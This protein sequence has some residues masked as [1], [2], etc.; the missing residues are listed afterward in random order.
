MRPPSP[1]AT[2]AG[3]TE[4]RGKGTGDFTAYALF[5]SW[6]PTSSTDLE[7]WWRV[8]GDH[9]LKLTLVDSEGREVKAGSVY[10]DPSKPVWTREGDPWHSTIRFPQAGCWRIV[11]E[12]GTGRYADLWVEVS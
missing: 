3:G 11:V 9:G 1:A 4:V 12:R 7:V 5:E 8:S 6:P 2:V 10:P